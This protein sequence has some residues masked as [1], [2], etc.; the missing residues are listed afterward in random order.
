MGGGA[1]GSSLHGEPLILTCRRG[2]GTASSH[3][4]EVQ[5]EILGTTVAK[6]PAK[7]NAYADGQADAYAAG[8]GPLEELSS[9][10]FI[11]DK[12]KDKK[13]SISAE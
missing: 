4:C 9:H 7:A 6:L 3:S 5:S 13:L 1:L 11:L 10:A 12:L 2:A 8:R